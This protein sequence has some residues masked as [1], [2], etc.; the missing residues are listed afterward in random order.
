MNKHQLI[1]IHEFD[2]VA[3]AI[4]GLTAGM[5]VAV[6][7][8]SCQVQNDIPV[9]HKIALQ[10]MEPETE[11]IKYGN[12]IGHTTKAVKKGEWVHSHNMQTSL[13]GMLEYTYEPTSGITEDKERVID[14]FLGYIRN[15]GEVGIRNEIWVIPTVSCVNH[16]VRM[17]AERAGKKFSESCDGIFAYPHNSGCSQ[18]GEDHKTTQKILASIIKHPNAGG[19]LVVSLGCENNNLMRI[20]VCA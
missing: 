10:D 6:G 1:Q 2:N 19:V 20:G 14:T 4:D 13:D 7:G 5:E 18:L 11:V 16:T 3:I 17:I 15:N 9:N 8:S 12:V